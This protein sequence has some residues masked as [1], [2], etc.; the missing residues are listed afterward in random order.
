MDLASLQLLY[1]KHLAAPGELGDRLR[2]C[3]MRGL[4]K[5]GVDGISDGLGIQNLSGLLKS[6]TPDELTSGYALDSRSLVD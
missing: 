6:R 4:L 5:T 1:Q 2:S 3:G